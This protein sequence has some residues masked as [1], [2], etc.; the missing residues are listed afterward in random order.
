MEYTIDFLQEAEH[1]HWD[2]FVRQSEAGTFFHL[3]GWKTVLERAFG[4]KTFYLIARRG[5]EIAGILPLAQTKSLLF[6]NR[7]SSTPFCVYGGPLAANREAGNALVEKAC[8]LAE[9]LNVDALEMRNLQRPD[10]SWPVRELY[11]TFRREIHADEA[12]NFKDVPNK[13][14]PMI[15]KA[16]KQGLASEPDAGVERLYRVYAESV[17]NL[18]TPVFARKYLELLRETF[19]EDC[20]VLMITQEGR[21][22]AGVLSFYYKD[23]VLPY[24]GGSIGEARHIKGTNHFMYWELIRR[25]GEAGYRLFDFGRSKTGTGPYSFKKNFGFT[26]EP[27]HY[28]YHLVR[29]NAVPEVNPTNPKYRG[30]IRLW[31]M[32]PLPVAN[33]LGPP[34][35]KSLG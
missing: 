21:D 20:D 17:R 33:R 6:G 14:R 13:Q 31:K 3:S 23:Q 12:Q 15:R 5:G 25:S 1:N 11:A 34:L 18:G 16:I 19:R 10:R 32:L 27:L 29:S 24:Y 35:A 9:S 26:P 30:F 8:Q 22:I 2:E 4:H 7:L 28:D